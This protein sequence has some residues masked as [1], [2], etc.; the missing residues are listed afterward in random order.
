M[1]VVAQKEICFDA[2][3][4]ALNY[5][6]FRS[7]LK[8]K[9]C[10]REVLKEAWAL[11]KSNVTKET[12]TAKASATKKTKTPKKAIKKV[13][14]AKKRVVV[15]ATPPAPIEYDR[16]LTPVKND[17]DNKFTT[18][19]SQA[20]KN[21][22]K[23][24]L[25]LDLIPQKGPKLDA[26]EKLTVFQKNSSKVEQVITDLLYGYDLKTSK[27]SGNDFSTILKANRDWI[28]NESTVIKSVKAVFQDPNFYILHGK[29]CNLDDQT[30]K[31]TVKSI[32]KV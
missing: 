13:T 4:K 7:M 22:Y 15:R 25:T 28:G 5:Q 1:K 27:L 6:D 23:L 10:S 32:K 20:V 19:Y 14:L 12:K 31:L 11:R 16:Y 21:S 2:A 18:N 8:K 3:K 29:N 24:A 30:L 26:K 9:G 17:R